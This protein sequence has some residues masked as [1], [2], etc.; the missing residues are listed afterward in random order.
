MKPWTV[1]TSDGQ[2]VITIG[3]WTSH[4]VTDWNAI[5]ALVARCLFN[6]ARWFGDHGAVDDNMRAMVYTLG[7]AGEVGE[8]A[9]KVKKALF[10]GP[11]L[12]EEAF[13]QADGEAI[14]ALIYILNYLG[15]RGVN[16]GSTFVAKEFEC[17]D[18]WGWPT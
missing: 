17:N 3:S 12:D 4:D 1:R 2:P 8:L 9:N 7:A 13:R 5:D 10:Y 18:R 11:T 16:I 15:T 6:S 14:D